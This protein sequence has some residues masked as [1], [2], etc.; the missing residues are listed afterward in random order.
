MAVNPNKSDR[1]PISTPKLLTKKAEAYKH[2]KGYKTRNHALRALIDKGL[3]TECKEFPKLR[4]II[5]QI[6]ADNQEK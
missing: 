6:I 2:F 3:E 1:Y 4:A 5:Q